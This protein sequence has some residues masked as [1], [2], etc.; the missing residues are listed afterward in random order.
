M[1]RIGESV[2]VESR[3]YMKKRDIFEPREHLKPFEY[4]EALEF[5]KAI[6]TTYKSTLPMVNVNSYSGVKFP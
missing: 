3:F 4:P 2:R 1:T 5:I 6:N